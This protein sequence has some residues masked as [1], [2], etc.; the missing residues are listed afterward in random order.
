MAEQ[1]KVNTDRLKADSKDIKDHVGGIQESIKSLRQHSTAMGDTIKD[2]EEM[3]TLLES[4]AETLEAL[5]DY[6]RYAVTRYDECEAKL[7]DLVK[8][9][10]TD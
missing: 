3:L 7:A 10:K 6:E 8:R 9:I 1:T 4:G 5:S 2:L